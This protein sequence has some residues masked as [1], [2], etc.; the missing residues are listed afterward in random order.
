MKSYNLKNKKKILQSVEIGKEDKKVWPKVKSGE[1]I[2]IIIIVLSSGGT[3]F[4]TKAQL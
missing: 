2:T 3:I 1:G 4:I